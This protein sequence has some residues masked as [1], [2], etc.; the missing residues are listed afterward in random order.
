VPKTIERETITVPLSGHN[1]GHALIDR[2]DYEKLMADGLSK[3]WFYNSNGGACSYVRAYQNNASGKLVGVAR[4][5]VG[6][7]PGEVVKYRDF[8]SRNLTFNNLYIAAGY[9]RRD[10]EEIVQNAVLG[11]PDT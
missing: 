2:V 3:T 8:N 9:S 5:I 6:A 10:D 7:G 11:Q 4:L 1:G